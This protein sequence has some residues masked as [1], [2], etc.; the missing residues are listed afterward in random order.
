MDKRWEE[1]FNNRQSFNFETLKQLL[2][3]INFKKTFKII[4]VVGTNGKGSVSNYLTQGLIEQGF[5]VGL[6]TSPHLVIPNE[7]IAVNNQLISD[8]E[9]F[10]IF[11]SFNIDDLHFFA[12][13]YLVALKYFE[14]KKC[15][16]VVMEAGIGGKRDV[17]KMIQG[18]YGLVT[19]ISF[20]H[21]ETL[22]YTLEAI[23][24]DKAQI[25]GE[26]TSFIIPQTLDKKLQDIFIDE[27]MAKNSQYFI[28]PNTGKNYQEENQK[29]A[30]FA[31]QTWFNIDFN[32]FSTPFGRSEIFLNNGYKTIFDVGHNEGGVKASLNY[33]K[34]EFKQVVI[35]F[36][37]TKD[38]KEI[39]SLFPDKKVF[40]YKV[41]E[42]FQHFDEFEEIKGLKLFY[43]NQNTSTLYIGSFF[44]IGELWK[45]KNMS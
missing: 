37:D 42:H 24:S 15:D 14:N 39:K 8:S 21:M 12:S 18:E 5:N 16:Y 28:A 38:T 44:L 19:S 32:N 34:D 2:K 26:N 43:K 10:D 33:I 36:K 41:N 27:A 23:A 20:D 1:I 4:H 22:G 25:M 3:K 11:K 29:L 45:I 9:F 7:R 30:H 17:T 31:L 35:A 40:F 13:T 6:F